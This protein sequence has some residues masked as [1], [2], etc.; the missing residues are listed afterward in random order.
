MPRLL[1]FTACEKVIFDEKDGLPSLITLF[2]E[3][4]IDIPQGE[5]IPEET[6]LPKQW[7]V[8]AQWQKTAQ[9]EGKRYEQRVSL[10]LPNGRGIHGSLITFDLQSKTHYNTV[11][12]LAFPVWVAGE[13]LI[14]LSLRD[15]DHESTW[16]ELARFSITVRHNEVTMPEGDQT[17]EQG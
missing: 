10:V 9:D 3:I 17:D 4:G 7:Y 2:D 12:T 1:T 11:K 16:R 15:L 5:S 6:Y 14:L 8:V 13:L